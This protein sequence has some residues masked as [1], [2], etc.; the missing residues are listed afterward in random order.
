ML[1]TGKL[2]WGWVGL[3][4]IYGILCITC[5]LLG[6]SNAVLKNKVY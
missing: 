6:K 3:G 4:C 5:Q 1:I 2:H